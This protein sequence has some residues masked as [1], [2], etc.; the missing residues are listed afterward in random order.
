MALSN[1]ERIRQFYARFNKGDRVLIAI[2][3]DPDAIAGALAV[4]RLL[5]KKVASLVLVNVNVIERPDNIALVNLLGVSLVYKD[6]VSLSDYNR[7]V[8]VDSQPEHHAWFSRFQPDVVIDHHPLAEPA[9]R[10]SSGYVDI[11]PTYGAVS[12]MLIE[13]LKAARIK[14]S[15]K[16]ATALYLGIKADTSNFER[17]ARLED[18]RAFQAIYKN[19]NV[20]LARRI[21]QAD[22]EP[23]SLDYFLTAL[24]RR[25]M[26]RGWLFAHLG[27]VHTPD[28]CVLV[29]D[30]FMRVNT[31]KWS[32]VSGIHKGTL[33]VI[34]RNNGI[35]RDAGQKASKVFGRMGSAGGH[36]S[37]ARAEVDLEKFSVHTGAQN[38]DDIQHWI[39]QHFLK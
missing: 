17:H 26:R 1:S 4:K 30:F 38:D 18:V 29:A 2:N 15:V 22:I 39:I 9:K 11:R 33:I 24:N 27:E 35:S 21:E 32:V 20:H 31:V 8:L 28:V 37:M 23:E 14:P 13:Y 7:Y 10:R 34:L 12:T 36:Q 6:E 5:W 25:V 3:A 16:L 19:V